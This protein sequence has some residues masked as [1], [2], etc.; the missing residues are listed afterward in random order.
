MKIVYRG[1]QGNY[2]LVSLANE[3][4][5]YEVAKNFVPKGKPY[6]ILD[7]DQ[8]PKTSEG[9]DDFNKLD[10]DLND[11]VGVEETP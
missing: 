9:M 6:K 2:V 8:T 7:K 5:I 4:N 3:S 10:I 1:D 11:G